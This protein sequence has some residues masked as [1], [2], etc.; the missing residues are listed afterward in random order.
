[1]LRELNRQHTYYELE[2][3]L[4]LSHGGQGKT[5][6]RY[7]T[8]TRTPSATLQGRIRALYA[9]LLESSLYVYPFRNDPDRMFAEIRRDYKRKKSQWEKVSK[10]KLIN[11]IWRNL[12][13]DEKNYTAQFT[14]ITSLEKPSKR[15]DVWRFLDK[16]WCEHRVILE[17][18]AFAILWSSH[19]EWRQNRDEILAQLKNLKPSVYRQLERSV[20]SL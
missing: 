14:V 16:G 13:A 3:L 17:Y 10:N 19:N 4:G 7:I 11:I 9:A 12:N 20:G 18:L 15:Y 6:R 1:M 5:I 8:G 2:T